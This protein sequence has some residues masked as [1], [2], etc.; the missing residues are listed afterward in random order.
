M[1]Y[2][3]IERKVFEVGFKQQWRDW[4]RAPGRAGRLGS[5]HNE[6]AKYIYRYRCK[7]KNSHGTQAQSGRD[8]IEPRIAEAVGS[9]VHEATG[10]NI[11]IKTNH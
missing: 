7:L 3:C 11:S 9:W 2:I 5:W 6:R 4:S 8:F 10:R 1:H